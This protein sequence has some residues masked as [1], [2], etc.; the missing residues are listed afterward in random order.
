MTKYIINGK[1][2]YP[3]SQVQLSSPEFEIRHKFNLLLEALSD[4]EEEK[5]YPPIEELL[6]KGYIGGEL[7]ATPYKEKVESVEVFVCPI[8]GDTKYNLKPTHYCKYKVGEVCNCD[9]VCNLK[10][11]E[12]KQEEWKGC[13]ICNCKYPQF[14]EGCYKADYKCRVCDNEPKQST[15][16]KEECEKLVRNI[17]ITSTQATNK[18]ISL[19]QSHLLKEIEKL[20]IRA[21]STSVK[22]GVEVL[23]YEAIGKKLQTFTINT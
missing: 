12:P 21:Y 8:H 1:E 23:D 18:I 11:E 20:E 3:M 13:G 6:K 22:N 19:V 9:C 5:K 7:E 17:D 10:Q 16:L 14:C 15:S 4:K 2:I